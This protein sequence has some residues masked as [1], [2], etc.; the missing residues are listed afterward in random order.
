[1]LQKICCDGMKP[2]CAIGVD[3]GGQPL[4]PVEVT[5]QSRGLRA[6]SYALAYAPAPRAHSWR[7]RMG[8]GYT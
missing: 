3:E 6:Q 4:N 2:D 7:A 5:H 8:P 1:M